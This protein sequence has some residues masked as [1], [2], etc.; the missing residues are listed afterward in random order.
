MRYIG[1]GAVESESWGVTRRLQEI[2]SITM[3]KV[4]EAWPSASLKVIF[5]THRETRLIIY[6]KSWVSCKKITPRIARTEENAK[7]CTPTKWKLQNRGRLQ[8]W[9]SYSCHLERCHWCLWK[10]AGFHEKNRDGHRR[11]W[12]LNRR[13]H[14]LKNC[15][16]YA[17]QTSK[18]AEKRPPAESGLELLTL[19]Y[20]FQ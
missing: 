12:N 5:L 8:S 4:T 9:T 20:E 14:E 1:I 2:C 10:E 17:P 6:K 15:K 16:K 11:K 3:S 18:F 7:I 19:R 13:L